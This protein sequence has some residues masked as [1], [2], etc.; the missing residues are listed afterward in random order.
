MPRVTESPFTP[1][2]PVAPEFFIGR[3]NEIT[4]LQ[5]RIK[6]SK[7]EMIFLVGERGIGK[8]SLASISR[9]LA[10]KE[11]VLGIHAFFGGVTTLE[12]MVRRI[13]D[14]LLKESEDRAWYEKVK[15]LF[16][17]N[18]KQIGVFGVSVTFS[19]TQEELNSLVEHFREVL[20][21]IATK[22]ADQKKG[23]L[24]ILDDINGL[25][26]R[27]EFAN[28]FKSLVD[29]IGTSSRRLPVSL[30][31]VGL[32]E[33]R[34]ALLS[35]QPSL[36]RVFHPIEIKP[37]TDDETREFFRAMF[38]RADLAVDAEA[39]E[40]LVK[41]SGGLPT[42]AHEIGDATFRGSEDSTISFEDATR[43]VFNAADIVGR[44]YVEPQVL[45][46]IKSDRYDKILKTIL[47]NSFRTEFTRSEVRE[48]LPSDQRDVFDNFV[49]R[50]K[51][52]GVIKSKDPGTYVFVNLLHSLY[53]WVSVQI[54]RN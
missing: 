5:T 6:S 44:K 25:G 37:W 24:I 9:V 45:A 51:K 36:S 11:G 20:E 21:S 22:L 41:Y 8:S 49:S 10:E 38:A 50:M 31:F 34:Q 14:R 30:V 42:L 43:G 47:G 12:E 17:K 19:A 48:A 3:L 16:G 13:L 35:N 18:I 33:N 28:W 32:E 40:L 26:A 23:I 54:E 15:D 52:L 7:P 1:G 39:L 29:E 53:L 4:E 27:R 46:A 2:L